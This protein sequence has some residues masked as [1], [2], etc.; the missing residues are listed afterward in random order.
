MAKNKNVTNKIET[1]VEDG[2]ADISRFAKAA[3]GAAKSVVNQRVK[4]VK[5][6]AAR[7]AKPKK[8]A[9]TSAKKRSA[10]RRTAKK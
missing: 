4:S 1:N 6:A 9:K 5:K 10:K 8:K 3:M 2:L 7:M